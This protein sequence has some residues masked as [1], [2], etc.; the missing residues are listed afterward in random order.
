MTNHRLGRHPALPRPADPP[1]ECTEVSVGKAR[2]SIH[3]VISL[4]PT[5]ADEI[6]QFLRVSMGYHLGD[7]LPLCGHEGVQHPPV[8]GMQ[9]CGSCKSYLEMFEGDLDDARWAKAEETF[10]WSAIDDA[11]RAVVGEQPDGVGW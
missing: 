6:V 11:V 1:Y 4:K 3:Y 9:P 8:P 5:V 2:Q 7:A 10:A